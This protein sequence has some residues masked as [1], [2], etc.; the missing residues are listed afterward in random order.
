MGL[1]VD[2]KSE[3]ALVLQHLALLLIKCLTVYCV[4]ALH[5]GV[6]LIKC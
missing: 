1:C 4:E 6:A 3:I 2:Y 5:I